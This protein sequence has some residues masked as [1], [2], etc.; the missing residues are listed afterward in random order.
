MGGM[1]S[2]DM[3]EW[4][5]VEPMLIGIVH[6]SESGTIDDRRISNQVLY[7]ISDPY[8]LER[9]LSVRTDTVALWDFNNVTDGVI[10][11]VS[12]NGHDA[13]L[14]DGTLVPDDCHLP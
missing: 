10:P 4:A 13:V 9:Y 3:P 11:D 1:G 12:G 5:C 8:E 6:G 7:S 2:S 14:V